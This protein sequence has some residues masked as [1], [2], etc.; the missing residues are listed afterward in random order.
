MELLDLYKAILKTA[1]FVVSDDGYISGQ[2]AGETKPALIKNK[3]MVLPTREHLA[4]SDLSKRIIFH[5]LSENIMHGESIVME[6]FRSML[7]IRM[8][9]TFAITAYTLLS[10]AASPA[11]HASLSPDQ[12]EFLSRVKHADEHTL[13]ALSKIMVEMP[14][15]QTQKAFVSI[16][17]K[18]G[19]VLAGKSHARL[20]VVNFPLYVALKKATDEVYGVKLRKKDI[21]AL[22]QLLEYMIPNIGE[23]E[24]YNRASDSRV[25]PFL[26]ALMHVV[27][28]ISAPLNDLVELF[29][30][31]IDDADELLINSEWVETFDNLEALIPQIRLVPM[32][33]GNEGST[34][35]PEAPKQENIVG[36]QS[37][38]PSAY[39][40]PTPPAL[41]TPAPPPPPWQSAPQ[42]H[43]QQPYQAP[44]PQGMVKTA[45][46]GLDFESVL[47][48][49]PAL[50]QQVGGFPQQQLQQQSL[51]RWAQPQGA[52]NQATTLQQG[53]PQQQGWGQQQPQGYVP[54][55]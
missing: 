6:K 18:R 31:K 13:K 37:P 52:F 33:A 41:P 29:R 24:A 35:K 4:S 12:S 3:S 2:I 8:N 26:D 23:P 46:G 53:W 50:A 38:A 40:P 7:N 1:N 47:R 48:N 19:G 30:N 5:P 20:G 22:I 9:S 49:N 32:Q 21:T 10:I 34:G 55:I 16:F 45:R 36:L 51:P 27:M 25:A 17:L 15:N 11:T 14:A 54:R 28:G 44:Q 43:F 42:Q 39:T